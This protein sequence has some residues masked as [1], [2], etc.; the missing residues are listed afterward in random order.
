MCEMIDDI[1]AEQ[2][3]LALARARKGMTAPIKEDHLV[4]VA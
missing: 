2:L 3:R 1:Q 4:A